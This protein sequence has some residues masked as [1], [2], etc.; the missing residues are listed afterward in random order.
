MVGSNR[1]I[2]K[3]FQ[4]KIPLELQLFLWECVDKLRVTKGDE[5]DYLQVFVLTKEYIHD[6]P[7][8]MIE[9]S[10]EIPEYKRKHVLPLSPVEMV[11]AKVFI[12]DSGDYTTALLSSEY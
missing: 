9:H 7:V 6:I 4:R 12:I 11:E 8:Q 3:G 2:T 10:Q 1:Y 5:M